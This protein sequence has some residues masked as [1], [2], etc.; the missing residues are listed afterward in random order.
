MCTFMFRVD[1]VFD[2]YTEG[3]RLSFQL[4]LMVLTYN[5]GIHSFTLGFILITA[6]DN[7]FFVLFMIIV[8]T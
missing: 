1:Y 8:K 6:L 3:Q 4:R 2:S 7:S 5:D